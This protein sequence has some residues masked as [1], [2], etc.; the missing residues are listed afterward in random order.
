MSLKQEEGIFSDI[1]FIVTSGLKKP[2]TGLEKTVADKKW[3]GEK[4]CRAA[5]WSCSSHKNVVNSSLDHPIDGLIL[6]IHEAYDQHYPLELSPDTIWLT[7]MSMFCKYIQNSGAKYSSKLISFSGTKTITLQ[8]DDFDYP[9]A[10]NPW[11]DTISQIC[12]QIKPQVVP[13]IYDATVCSFSTTTETSSIASKIVLMSCVKQ[14]FKFEVTT[15]CGIPSIT[16]LGTKM[17]WQSI[18]SKLD[19]FCDFDLEEWI[20]SLKSIIQQFVNVFDGKV[21]N[22]FWKNMY[23]M[24]NG[25]GGPYIQGWIKHLYFTDGG[26]EDKMMVDFPLVRSQVPVVWKANTFGII[27]HLLFCASVGILT[28]NP[29]TKALRAEPCWF[30]TLQ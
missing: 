19:A 12:D 20:T 6:S 10:E 28:Q 1:T 30:L 2:K 3:F 24:D 27:F 15:L 16:L 17:D 25:S 8:K 5:V 4:F 22:E 21:D 29:S 23:K 11:Q 7:I 26:K 13:K 18:I 14:S 9:F